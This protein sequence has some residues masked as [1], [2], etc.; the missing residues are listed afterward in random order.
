M[1]GTV[2]VTD[3]GWGIAEELC[4]K[5]E[6][7]GMGAIRVGFESE[8]RD[9]SMQNEAGRTVFRA[10]PANNMHVEQVCNELDNTDICGVIHLAALKLAGVEWD[11]DTYPSSQIS[12][13]AHGWFALLK[14]LDSKLGAL[15]NGIVASVTTLDGRHGNIGEL[16][17]SIQSAATGV[18][19]SY[20]FEQPKL[21]ARALDLHPE[22]V[23]DSTHAAEL[24]FNDI[25]NIGGEVEIG[26]DRDERR[27]ALVAF[28]EKLEAERE[29]L[30]STDTWIVSGGGSGVTAASIIG[31]AQA[32]TDANAHF[33]LL[34]RSQLIEETQSWID[35]SEDQLN[36]RKMNLRDTMVTTSSDGKVTMVEW[37]KEWQKY[38]RS[39]DVYLTLDRIEKT[40]NK[41]RYHS[42]DVMD[43]EN[44]IALGKSLKRKITGVIHGAGLEDSKLVAD[45]GHDI[46]DRVVRVKLDGW[47]S[48]M[49]AAESSGTKSLKFAACFTSVAGRFGNGG[50]T[51]Y[52]AANC[53]LDAEMARL[54]ASGKCRAVAIGW[55]G[56]KDV[57]MAT[58][59]SIEAVF[60]AAGIETL[61]V[62]TGVDIFVD[63]A[64][65]GG[66]RRV[67]ACG[68]L[69][70]MDRF[71][72]FRE[73]PLRLPSEMSAIIADPT[74][75][76]LID[77]VI[78]LD[79]HTSLLTETTLS[80]ELHPFL[81]DHAIDGI[82]YHPGV[83]ALEMFAENALLLKP[84]T[85]LA[86]FENVSFGLPVKLLKDEIKVRVVAEYNN[87]DG[88]IHWINCKLVSDL[89]NS[90]GEIF[91]EREH[92]SATVR[93]VEKSDDLSNFLQSEIEQMP[94][95]GTPP[96]DELILLPSFIYQR[97]FHGPRF[98]S[99]GGIIRGIGNEMTPGAD[100]IALMRNQLPITEQF[101]SEVDGEEVLL[102]A[103]PM[104]IEAGFQNSGFVAMESEGFSSLPIGID[105]ST[106]IRVPER[107]EILRVRS[108][109]VAVEEAGVTVHDVVII[110]DDEAPV[111][112]M[113][114]LR[115]KSMAP[116]SDEQRFI[117]ER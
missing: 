26:I 76:A 44:M 98:Q 10:D 67:L 32:S 36:Q 91:G 85:C 28:D 68:S 102:E 64:L 111:L 31:V 42:V 117:L 13:A 65:A 109:R 1:S 110:G 6:Q 21:R 5:L 53:V 43:R 38:T 35:W 75:F 62:T 103:L 93:L 22:I 27:W 11:E 48:L 86:G 4:R 106:N 105:W 94:D 29:P 72:S 47:K 7:H 2:V 34:G 20:S 55:T 9:M 49:A 89:M 95:I 56:W 78:A 25:F 79:E 60:A 81:V 74:R 33:V 18:T 8:I 107:D 17:N 90:K 37:N 30:T 87:S 100:G 116:V 113:K 23:L 66:K 19:K 84:T 63:E 12:L 108:V 50:Q 77:K 54:T 82:P 83:M 101:S 57:G 112:A 41:A 92:H 115:L 88:D 114:G 15:E 104:L 51:D 39:M 40:G 58:R 71:D 96:L 61:D 73:P 3:D 14:G 16:F 69:G 80:T 70:L 99:H 46:F 52:A 45:K 59:G 97:Y 24:I